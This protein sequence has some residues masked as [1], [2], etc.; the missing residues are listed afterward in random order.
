MDSAVDEEEQK[1]GKIRGKTRSGPNTDDFQIAGIEEKLDSLKYEIREHVHELDT[2]IQ[3]LKDNVK[4]IGKELNII[5]YE[6]NTV[7]SKL[8]ASVDL[9]IERKIE[10]LRSDIK[11]H[12]HDL[13]SK[14]NGLNDVFMRLGNDLASIKDEFNSGPKEA[15]AS[16]DIMSSI[17]DIVPR[18]NMTYANIS[19]PRKKNLKL[20]YY[21]RNNGKYPIEVESYQID[22]SR[23]RMDDD[24]PVT[25]MKQGV[26]YDLDT[27]D[28]SGSINPGEIKKYLANI[29]FINMPRIVGLGHIFSR[30]IL[31][32]KTGKQSREMIGSMVGGFV[33][34]EQIDYLSRLSSTFTHRIDLK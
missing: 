15:K 23:E 13:S 5:R 29:S 8:Q 14:I 2:E 24:R 4:E 10:I 12:N 11:Q 6:L 33:D 7:E 1:V 22:L 28:V 25:T 19:N 27:L 3:I 17:N 16:P 18:I 20:V 31:K 26:D 34:E 21:L 32:V 30:L 9:T